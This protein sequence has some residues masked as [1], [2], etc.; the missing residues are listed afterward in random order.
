MEHMRI[1]E[2][3]EFFLGKRI[4]KKL[5]GSEKIVAGLL[6]YE[7]GQSTPKHHHLKQDGFFYVIE[8]NGRIVVGEEQA[9]LN[10]KS[11]VF[12]P[13]GITH[14]ITAADDSRLVVLFLKAPASTGP[15]GPSTI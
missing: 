15:S 1:E 3:T 11:L 14:G 7:A 13:A 6:C 2:V 5:L 4:R 8:G 9:P 12:V 10:S